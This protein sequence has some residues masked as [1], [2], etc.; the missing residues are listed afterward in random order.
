MRLMELAYGSRSDCDPI[1]RAVDARLVA[2]LAV[3]QSN[4]RDRDALM[5]G[6][7]PC[8]VYCSR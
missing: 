2:C 5:E 6:V 8:D 7:W 4:W 3:K 1:Q